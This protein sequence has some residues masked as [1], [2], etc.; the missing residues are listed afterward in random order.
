MKSERLERLANW[1][2]PEARHDLS[3]RDCMLYGL[4][5]G[6]LNLSATFL[7]AMGIPS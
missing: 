3:V 1:S 5:V 4:S 2:I 6:F 7:P